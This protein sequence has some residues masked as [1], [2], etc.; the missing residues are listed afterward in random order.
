MRNI[1][2]DSYDTIHLL[3]RIYKSSKKP[4]VR[5]RAHCIILSIRGYQIKEIGRILS[6]HINTVYNCFNNFE[7]DGLLS[8][9]NKK[10]QGRKPTIEAAHYDFLLECIKEYPK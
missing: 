5:Q 1:Y 2:C 10:G 8:L 6:V 4:Q 9:Y 3:D 7:A